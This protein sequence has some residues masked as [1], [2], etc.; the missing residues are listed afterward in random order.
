[1]G[2]E[3]RITALAADAAIAASNRR[4]FCVLQGLGLGGGHVAATAWLKRI[5]LG[6]AALW[7]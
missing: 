7:M 3:G 1:M 5:P 2:R 6:G 4:S